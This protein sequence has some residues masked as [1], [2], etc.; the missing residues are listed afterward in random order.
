MF[1][2]ANPQPYC[3]AGKILLPAIHRAAISTTQLIRRAAPCPCLPPSQCRH[4]HHSAHS[5]LRWRR[6]RGRE[7]ERE[8][9]L[10][11]FHF[12]RAARG[13][14]FIPRRRRRRRS[15]FKAYNDDCGE[16]IEWVLHLGLFSVGTASRRGPEKNCSSP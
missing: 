12:L 10:K 4:H 5:F 16:G 9:G 11:L 1:S 6:G 2:Y 3:F 14:R 7:R 8:G 13:K 15:S